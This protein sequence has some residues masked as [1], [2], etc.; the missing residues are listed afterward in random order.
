[1]MFEDA[2]KLKEEAEMIK[3][4]GADYVILMLHTGNAYQP[5]P[6]QQTQTL[7]DKILKETSVD[8]IAGHHPHNIQ[9]IELQKLENKYKIGAYS[10]GKLR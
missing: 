7:Y 10:L 1:M 6:S 2:F 3:V 8:F 5:F 4:D 9:G